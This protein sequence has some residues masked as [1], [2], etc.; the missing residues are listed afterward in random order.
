M[1]TALIMGGVSQGIEPVLGNAFIQAS[2][3]GE[4]ERIN[5]VFLKLLKEK[6]IYSKDLVQHVA[7]KMGS[8]QDLSDLSAHEKLVLKTAFEIDQSVIIR[9]AS[10]RQPKLCQSQSLNL[11]FSSEEN[12]EYIARQ[13]TRIVL[14]PN[15]TSAYYLRSQSGVS[16]SRETC[17]A[18]T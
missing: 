11:F 12:E 9:K 4:V 2:A 5:P 10:Q 6:G 17:I 13:H 15:I 1:S 18:C 16:A 3:A 7:S 8:V 14:D